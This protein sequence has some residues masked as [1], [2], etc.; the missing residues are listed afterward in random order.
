MIHDNLQYKTLRNHICK[1]TAK[2][3]FNFRVI[4]LSLL[5]ALLAPF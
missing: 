5:S 3:F 4:Y 2:I 1:I